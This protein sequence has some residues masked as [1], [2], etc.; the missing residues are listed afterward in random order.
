MWPLIAL[1]IA[2]GIIV[3]LFVERLRL[4]RRLDAAHRDQLKLRD[5]NH[6]LL[7]QRDLVQKELDSATKNFEAALA[8]AK[9]TFD[10]AAAAALRQAG[11]QFLQ[12]AQQNLSAKQQTATAELEQRKTAIEALLKPIRDSLDKHADAVAQ[13]EKEREGAYGSLRQQITTLIADQD[14]L[15]K[16]TGNLVT[17]LRRPEVRGRWGEL[18]L[19]RVV[20]LAGMIEHCDYDEQVAKEGLRPDMVVHLPGGREIVVDAKTPID[21]FLSAVESADDVA[22]DAQ[23]RRHLDQIE[24]QVKKLSSKQYQTQ[25]ERCPDFVVLFIPGE[26]F[27]QPAVQL[28]PTLLEDAMASSVVIATPSTLV[29]LLRAVAMGWREERIAQNAQQVSNMG[30]ELHERIANVFDKFTTLGGNLE[31]AV[32]TY[33][34]T[35]ASFESRVLV[36]ARRFKELG[37]DSAKELPAEGTIKPIETQVRVQ[38]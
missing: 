6:D 5:E 3:F 14:K 31:R 38:I 33:N 32:K 26:S 23:F 20:E 17:A 37:A 4:T 28:K 29:S 27:L 25:F 35:F 34:E 30:K 10:A 7:R 2:A 22:R 36:T 8:R 15:R 12:L 11:E 9:E 19:K 13:V 24:Q 1:A 21:A 16:E 18:G